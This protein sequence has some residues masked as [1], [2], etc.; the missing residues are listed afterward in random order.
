MAELADEV[1]AA[2]AGG[3]TAALAAIN[4]TVP[5]A[6]AIRHRLARPAGFPLL[7]TLNGEFMSFSSRMD[8]ASETRHVRYV[9]LL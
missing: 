1:T 8:A 5:K 4:V 6:A 9:I 2:L 7:N 3:V